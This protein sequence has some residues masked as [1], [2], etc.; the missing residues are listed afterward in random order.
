MQLFRL[1]LL[2]ALAPYQDR[3]YT[4]NRTC[5]TSFQVTHHRKRMSLESNHCLMVRIS[6]A[7]ASSLATQEPTANAEHDRIPFRLGLAETV[8]GIKTPHEDAAPQWVNEAVG[9]IPLCC[10]FA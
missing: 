6:V 7:Q 10:I 8:E 2:Q 5:G 4:F 9:T 3:L 1:K